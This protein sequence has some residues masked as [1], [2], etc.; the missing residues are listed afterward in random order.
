M[1]LNDLYECGS[2]QFVRN[3]YHLILGREPDEEGFTHHVNM[4]RAGRS[5]L[6]IVRGMMRSSEGRRRGVR[7]AGLRGA[8][9]WDWLMRKSHIGPWLDRLAWARTS[10]ETLIRIWSLEERCRKL[11]EM[12]A[13]DAIASA[14]QGRHSQVKGSDASSWLSPRGQEIFD[15]LRA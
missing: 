8:L 5:R 10:D 12:A 14:G 2:E 6:R 3:C 9:I 4:L 1:Q 7:I 11:V 15:E 13:D